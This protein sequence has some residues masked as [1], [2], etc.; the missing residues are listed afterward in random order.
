MCDVN[1]LQLSI[2]LSKH[3]ARPCVL[4][5][6]RNTAGYYCGGRVRGKHRAIRK[7]YRGPRLRIPIRVID[8]ATVHVTRSVGAGEKEHIAASR[9]GVGKF[10][11]LNCRRT[12]NKRTGELYKYVRLAA[13]ALAGYT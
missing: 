4:R 7:T 11:R 5:Y 9:R 6:K 1:L 13:K 2:W 3:H 8:L 12:N 10:D